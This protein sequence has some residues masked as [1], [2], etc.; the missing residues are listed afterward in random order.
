MSFMS[1]STYYQSSFGSDMGLNIG[2]LVTIVVTGL[3]IFLE[4]TQPLLQERTIA[5]LGR[6]RLRFS[7]VTWILFIIFM[8]IVYTKVVMILAT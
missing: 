6:L 7:T 1:S 8:G 5:I 4:L 2:I 3:L